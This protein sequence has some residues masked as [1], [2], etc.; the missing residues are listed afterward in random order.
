MTLFHIIIMEKKYNYVYITTNII[1]G[2]QYVGDRSCNYDPQKDNYIGSGRPYFQNAKRKYGKENF[3]KEILEY[4]DSRQKAFDA[5]EKYIIQ[6]NT[7][8]P[9]GYNL[10]PK[11]G[12]GVVGCFSENTKTQMGISRTGE[13]NGMFHKN[14]SADAKK[15]QS[16]ARKGKYPWNKNKH[17]IYSEETIKKM[18]AIDHSGEKNPMFGKR[19]KRKKGD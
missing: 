10:S 3:K 7:L 6:Y 2:K 8:Y 14:H 19:Y 17:G 12:V 18:K 4:F 11:G 5:Q 13:R 9:F 16:E 15:K 1:T